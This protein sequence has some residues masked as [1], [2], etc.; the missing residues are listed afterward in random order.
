V[1]SARV[2]LKESTE[3]MSATNSAAGIGPVAPQERIATLDILRGYALF[4]VLL[5]NMRNFDVPGQEWTGT[6]DQ[7]ALWLTI[8]LGDSKFWT[9]FSFLFGLGFALQLERAQARGVPFLR[10]YLR[11]LGV[12]LI[13][14]T[15]HHLIYGGDILFDY[16]VAGF[17]LPLFHASSI[18]TILLVASVSFVIPMVQFGLDVRARELARV[19][20]QVAQLAAREAAQREAQRVVGREEFLRLVTRG[21]FREY[22]AYRA[23]V[24]ARR[25]A[26]L[27][28]YLWRPG[29][30]GGIL[31]G[32]FPLFLLGLYFGRRRVFQDL[33]SYL[34]YVRKALPWGAG[35]G[36]AG[37]LV[38]VAGQWPTQA[39]P[40]SQ[41]TRHFTGILWFV[42]TPA[43]SFSYAA[44]MILLVQK[45]VW[46]KR[47]AP[48]AAIGRMALTNYLLQSLIFTTLF[49]GYGLG[50]YGAIGPA[51]N[52]AV[53]L[54][55][56]TIQAALSVWW[57]GRFR[58]GPAEWLWRSLTYGK[59]QPMRIGEP[60][61]IAI[62]KSGTLS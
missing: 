57:L 5:I 35:L 34:P 61:A 37:T 31:G 13:F 19:N 43:L 47:L 11:R 16:A 45:E 58:F 51:L 8:A 21:S 38:S 46:M 54:L 3:A 14:G 23:Q 41:S 4:G 25:Y 1:H 50:L 40:Y 15:L 32:P 7:V 12:L 39:V 55:I 44:A 26:S 52:V 49:F 42:G 17:L 33:P 20:P 48:L 28:A 22:V 2:S 60:S 30:P 27:D 10:L 36:L 9:L 29:G 59:L 6:V 53:T 62:G 24:F 18:K 56:Y